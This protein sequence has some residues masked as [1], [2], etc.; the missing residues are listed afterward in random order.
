[1]HF[2]RSNLNELLYWHSLNCRPSQML[3]SETESSSYLHQETARPKQS[4]HQ[5][6]QAHSGQGKYVIKKWVS[7]CWIFDNPLAFCASRG[8]DCLSTHVHQFD[9][10][11]SCICSLIAVRVRQ[12]KSKSTSKKS[13]KESLVEIRTC[14]VS[15]SPTTATVSCE[16]T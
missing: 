12:G 4:V 16:G 1:M 9:W 6:L 11:C 13:V 2:C 7:S 8:I 3:S 14:S 15:V 5:V 10:S